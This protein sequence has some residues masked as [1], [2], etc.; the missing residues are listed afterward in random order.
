METAIQEFSFKGTNVRTFE[1]NGEPWFVA[2]DVGMALGLSQSAV[3]EIMKKL[4]DIHVG[5]ISIDTNKGA[6]AYSIISEQGLYKMIIRSRKPNA[7]RFQDWI[8]E[9][10]L[11]SIRKTGSY[12]IGQ[13]LKPLSNVVYA[14]SGVIEEQTSNIYGINSGI[15]TINKKL[16]TYGKILDII[17]KK[18]DTYGIRLNKLEERSFITI[19]KRDA[20]VELV[21]M[22]ATRKNLEVSD[23]FDYLYEVFNSFIGVDLPDRAKR[24]YTEPLEYA[25]NM[26][27][28]NDL[29]FV[30][31]ILFL[32]TSS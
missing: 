30:A 31:T 22:H 20:I 32:N 28:I 2:R 24:C 21:N 16:D 8:T 23:V 29:Y 19:S 27:Y 13:E 26:N 1:K 18:L 7:E 3:S 10:V 12:S 15:Y 14:M 9:E 25:N 4:K 6:R 11:P 17:N 5:I